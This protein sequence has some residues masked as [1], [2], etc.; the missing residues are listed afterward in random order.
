M[1]S[2]NNLMENE[3][4]KDQMPIY[5]QIEDFLTRDWKPQVNIF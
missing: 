4:I 3:L 2:K 5:M 1:Y